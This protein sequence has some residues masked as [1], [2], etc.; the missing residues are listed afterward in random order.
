MRSARELTIW[1]YISGFKMCTLKE[2]GISHGLN[3][4]NMAPS[5]PTV[6]GTIVLTG[7]ADSE[8]SDN[9]QSVPVSRL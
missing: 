2:D 3:P 4:S 8:L 5:D 7:C 9:V 6:F 1:L